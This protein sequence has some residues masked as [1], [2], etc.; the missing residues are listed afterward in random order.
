V[1]GDDH[2][3]VL[4][5]IESI[6]HVDTAMGNGGRSR[7]VRIFCVTYP[8]VHLFHPIAH[9]FV[10]VYRCLDFRLPW[11]KQL[12]RQQPATLALSQQCDKA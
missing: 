10:F 11:K 9:F 3:A 8:L 1:L 6:E 7:S 12:K 2:P 4:A 5:T